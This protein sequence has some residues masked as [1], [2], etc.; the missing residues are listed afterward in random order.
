M[1]LTDA[2]ATTIPPMGGHCGQH[3][4]SVE[5]PTNQQGQSGG[6]INHTPSSDPCFNPFLSLSSRLWF[7]RTQGA[8]LFDKV[9]KAYVAHS[10]HV[11]RITAA[12]A[13]VLFAQS[14]LCTP[15]HHNAPTKK[16]LKH[17]RAAAWLCKTTPRCCSKQQCSC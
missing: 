8:E 1:A 15:P 16:A 4:A 9:Q 10:L 7:L 5:P 11:G 6:S 14:I 2:R 17:I 13:T 3:T 12:Q